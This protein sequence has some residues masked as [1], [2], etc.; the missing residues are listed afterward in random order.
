MRAK[1]PSKNCS[2]V[3]SWEH[4]KNCYEVERMEEMKTEEK[5]NYLVALR[6]RIR[7]ANPIRPKPTTVPYRGERGEIT[8]VIE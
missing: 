5:D 3:D 8:N 4:F 1:C 6:K 7:V 2:Q